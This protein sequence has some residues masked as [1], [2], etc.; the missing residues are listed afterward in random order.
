[1]TMETPLNGEGLLDVAAQVFQEAAFCFIEPLSYEITLEKELLVASLAF[2]G[3]VTGS[4]LVATPRAFARQ[5]AANLLGLELSDEEAE[6]RSKDALGELL[7]MV[8]G[9][10]FAASLGTENDVQLGLPSTKR[11]TDEEFRLL[12][13]TQTFCVSGLVEE[14][15][16]V[17]F[18]LTLLS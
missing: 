17:D 18:A 8:A 14:E 2:S 11:M 5:A 7:N 13:V 16:R 6:R 10:F 12:A 9:V 15:A 1:M 3:K 4:L